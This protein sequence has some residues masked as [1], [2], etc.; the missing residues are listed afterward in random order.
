MRTFGAALVASVLIATSAFAAPLAPGKPAGVKSA[1]ENGRNNLLLIA[2]V[3]VVGLGIGLVASG[4]GGDNPLVT[5]TLP[6]PG[7]SGSSTGTTP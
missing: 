3:A 4:S 5:S 6:A 7:T 1:Q 2:G